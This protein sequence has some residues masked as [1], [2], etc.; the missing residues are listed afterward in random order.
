MVTTTVRAS[1]LLRRWW[2]VI[3]ACASGAHV[4]DAKEWMGHRHLSTTM[5]YVHHGPR[6]EAAAALERHFT[7]AAAELDEL[8]RRA[9]V[10][11]DPYRSGT[12]RN[13]RVVPELGAISGPF[14]SLPGRDR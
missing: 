5:R 1:E 8:A 12:T 9:V 6:P 11:D 10:R 3:A 13:D 2:W 4:N 14:P 7:G